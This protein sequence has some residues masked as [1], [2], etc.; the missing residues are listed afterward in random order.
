VLDVDP[1]PRGKGDLGSNPSQNMQ[2]QIAAKPS[3]LCCHLANTNEELGALAISIPFFAKLQFV[4]WSLVVVV[5]VVAGVVVPSSSCCCC[6][7]CCY[8]YYYYY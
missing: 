6:Y 5:V 3:V 8:Y 1:D 2:L 7:C 4:V